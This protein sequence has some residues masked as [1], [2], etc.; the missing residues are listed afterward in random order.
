MKT[1][2]Y[3]LRAFLLATIVLACAMFSGCNTVRVNVPAGANLSGTI[4]VESNQAIWKS[5]SVDEGEGQIDQTTSPQTDTAVDT[6][7]L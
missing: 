1:K 4:N 6:G 3:I 7:A 2:T 5:N